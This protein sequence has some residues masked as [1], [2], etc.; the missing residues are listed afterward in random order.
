MGMTAAV[1]LDVN[2]TLI[3]SDDLDAACWSE[4]F[5]S[6]CYDIEADAVRSHIGKGGDQLI[7]ALLPLAMRSARRKGSSTTAPPC[8]SAATQI[9]S[10]PSAT[11]GRGPTGL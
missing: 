3:D 9:A 10:N 4:T 2:G 11:C 6:F 7:P 1:I 5:R 8:L